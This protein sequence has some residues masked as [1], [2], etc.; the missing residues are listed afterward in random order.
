M[1]LY[2]NAGR[3]PIPLY[4]LPRSRRVAFEK[5]GAKRTTLR[6]EAWFNLDLGHGDILPVIWRWYLVRIKVQE[7]RSVYLGFEI[8]TGVALDSKT[9]QVV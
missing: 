2:H 5:L 9:C 3:F 6:V 7:R 4:S 8:R 1:L